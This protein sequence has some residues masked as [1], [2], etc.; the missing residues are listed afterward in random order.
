VAIFYLSA[1][2]VLYPNAWL[3]EIFFFPFVLAL[4]VGVSVSNARAVLEALCG[5]R[6]EFSRTPKY[7]VGSSAQHKRQRRYLVL[8]SA[9][10]VVEILFAAYFTRFVFL[11]FQSHEFLSLP[12]LMLFQFGFTYV[13]VSS[14]WELAVRVRQRETNLPISFDS[15]A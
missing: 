8:R 7:G 5:H 13:A 4:G 11:A 1:Q 10:P 2:R 14:V 9:V 3:R 15:L 6:S 12:F